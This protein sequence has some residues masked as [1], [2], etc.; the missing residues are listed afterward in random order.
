[1]SNVPNFMKEFS[2]TVADRFKNYK[3]ETNEIALPIT[4]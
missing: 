4:L 1:M 2:S 3:K